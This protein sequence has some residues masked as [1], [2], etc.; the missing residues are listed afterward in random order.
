MKNIK[1]TIIRLL[2]AN[3]KLRD[4]DS[5]LIANIW[6]LEVGYGNLSKMS[7]VDLLSLFANGKL[8]SPETIRRQRQKIQELH[9]N[10]RGKSYT[11][12]QREQINVKSFLKSY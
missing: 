11:H 10:L 3:A 5:D 4:N 2:Y 8:T 1:Q 6:L 12:R 7:A 9:P